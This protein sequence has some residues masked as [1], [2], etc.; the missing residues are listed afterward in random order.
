MYSELEPTRGMAMVTILHPRSWSTF[1]GER[2]DS[3]APLPEL[4]PSGAGLN[5]SWGVENTNSE[6]TNED[7]EL[8]EQWCSRTL[9]G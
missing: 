8:L 4:L 1:Q 7:R 6:G 9:A 5:G 2:L 3:Q